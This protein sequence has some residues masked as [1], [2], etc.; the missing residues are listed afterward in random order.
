MESREKR[1]CSGIAEEFRFP[2][3]PNVWLGGETGGGR[4]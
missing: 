4:E 1:I 2:P 3:V